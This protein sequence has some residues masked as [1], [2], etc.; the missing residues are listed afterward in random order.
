MKRN[1]QRA[2]R[3]SVAVR[4]GFNLMEVILAMGVFALGM[5]SIASLFPTAISQQRETIYEVT[6]RQVAVG[7]KAKFLAMVESGVLSY[8]HDRKFM[9]REGTLLAYTED[10]VLGIQPLINMKRQFRSHTDSYHVYVPQVDEMEEQ[11]RNRI[12]NQDDYPPFDDYFSMDTLSYPSHIPD[13]KPEVSGRREYYWYPFIRASDMDSTH[14]EWFAYICVLR[15]TSN[16]FAPSIRRVRVEQENQ[17]ESSSEDGLVRLKYKTTWGISSHDQN[18]NG[19]PDRISA[20]DTVLTDTGVVLQIFMADTL[21]V[22]VKTLLTGDVNWLYYGM[23]NAAESPGEDRIEVRSPLIYI[24]EF[25][26]SPKA[27]S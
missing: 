15:Q 24:E 7:A 13:D 20:G 26:F 5:V 27:P 16:G 10:T 19:I 6:A 9:L 12:K 11:I 3:F 2:V 4:R 17:S 21:G 14:P 23:S 18:N 22:E 8:S 25:A 1:E